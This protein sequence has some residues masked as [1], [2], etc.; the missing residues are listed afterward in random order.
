MPFIDWTDEFTVDGGPIDDQHR[1]LVEIVNKF[2]EAIRR[3]KG[4]RIMTEILNDLMGYTQEHFSFEENILQEAGYSQL[5]QHQ[6]QHRQL[7]QKLEKYQFEFS[8]QGK[9]VTGDLKD[10]LKYWL[11]SHILKDDKAYVPSLTRKETV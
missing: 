8:Q 1:Q 6:S 7:I 5:K 9:R 3:G 2:D 4:T 11:T 10:F